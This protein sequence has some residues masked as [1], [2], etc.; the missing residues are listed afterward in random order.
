MGWKNW[1]YWLK[2][3]IIVGVITFILLGGLMFS[4]GI[5]DGWFCVAL[6]DAQSCTFYE[7]L[8]SPWHWIQIIF[9]TICGFILGAIIGFI[10]KITKKHIKKNGTKSFLILIAWP[11]GMGIFVSIIGLI[12]FVLD[13]S[14]TNNLTYFFI[15]G[16]IIGIIIDLI[17]NLIKKRR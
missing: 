1:P 12:L 9:L 4:I 7:F 11:I 2:G 15:L 6:V 14:N 10:I 5:S 3:G 16:I 8:T 17:M 13:I